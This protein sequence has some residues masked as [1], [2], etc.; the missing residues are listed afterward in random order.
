[1]SRAVSL[2]RRRMDFFRAVAEAEAPAVPE[3][4]DDGA[5]KVF[6]RNIADRIQIAAVLSAAASLLLNAKLSCTISMCMTEHFVANIVG[7][8]LRCQL[9]YLFS[10]A[11]VFG[12]IDQ[13]VFL[14][15]V[16]CRR[17]RFILCHSPLCA[18]GSATWSNNFVLARF[19]SGGARFECFGHNKFSFSVQKHTKCVFSKCTI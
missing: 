3:T 13:L 19:R 18:R 11:T 5:E 9:H 16:W 10:A 7:S 12:W 14:A 15:R 17:H 1:M 2:L 8:N 6:L 4:V